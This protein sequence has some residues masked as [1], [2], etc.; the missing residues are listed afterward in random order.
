M[1]QYLSQDLVFEELRMFHE[2]VMLVD[3]LVR[4]VM[5]RL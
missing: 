4:L 1:N 2:A 5:A 3:K